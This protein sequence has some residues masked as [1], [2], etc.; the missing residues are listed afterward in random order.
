MAHALVR[1]QPQDAP[2]AISRR[3]AANEVRIRV[4][5]DARQNCDTKPGLNRGEQPGRARVMHRDPI[6][7]VHAVQKCLIMAPE[8][9]A[10]APDDRVPLQFLDRCRTAMA[11]RIVAAAIERPIVDSEATSYQPGRLIL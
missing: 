3:N 5:N 9:L 2:V 10:A 11:I 8:L 7:K 6:L 1:Q 4:S